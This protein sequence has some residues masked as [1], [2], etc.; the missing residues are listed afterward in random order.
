MRKYIKYEMSKKGSL[1][2]TIIFIFYNLIVVLIFLALIEILLGFVYRN[3]SKIPSFA[4]HA[5]AQYYGQL[6]RNTIQVESTCAQYNPELFYLLKPGICTFSNIEFTTPVEINQ[7][8]LR[9]TDDSLINPKMVFL[10]DSFTMGWGVNQ[11]QAFPQII[12]RTRGKTL[13]AGISS[14]GTVRE[15]LLLKSIAIDS[16]QTIIIQYHANDAPENSEFITK[17]NY[18]P[19]SSQKRYDSLCN[20]YVNGKKYFP[21]KLVSRIGRFLLKDAV[22]SSKQESR[23]YQKEAINFLQ[24]LKHFESLK[25]KKIVIFEVGSRNVNNNSFV[26]ALEEEITSGDYPEYIMKAVLVKLGNEFSE[27]DY[28]ILDDHL[29]AQGHQKLANILSKFL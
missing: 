3:P 20:A 6:A 9:D 17:G 12:G 4:K 2:S 25:L 16:T 15:L 27:N 21:G 1:K 24:V 28:Y 5:F 14:F 18:L 19:V 29:N 8:G 22:A 26:N 13:N 7:R 11:N 23:N 10:G